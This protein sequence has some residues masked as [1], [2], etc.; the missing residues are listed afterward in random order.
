M[1]EV[2]QATDNAAQ[3][4]LDALNQAWEYYSAEPEP[5]TDDDTNDYPIAA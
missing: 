2:N 5:A 4:A 1:S 3:K